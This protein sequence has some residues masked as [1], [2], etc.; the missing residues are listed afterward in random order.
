MTGCVW[1]QVKQSTVD[2]VWPRLRLL[3]RCSPEDKYNLVRAMMDSRLNDERQ[4][5]AVTGDGTNDGPALRK[6]HV[7]LAMVSHAGDPER[8][9]E[10][11]QSNGSRCLCETVFFSSCKLPTISVA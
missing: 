8:R 3:A 9:T 10:E 7:G 11:F 1:C 2:S 6:A 5:V 4:I